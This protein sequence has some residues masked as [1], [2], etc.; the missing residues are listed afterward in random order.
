MLFR[1]EMPI[2]PPDWDVR[3]GVFASDILKVIVILA[4]AAVVM[5]VLV[6]QGLGVPDTIDPFTLIGP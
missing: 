1:T 3:S 4:L 5:L 6:S 2:P